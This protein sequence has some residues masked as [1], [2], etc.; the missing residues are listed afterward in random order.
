MP[1]ALLRPWLPLVSDVQT[2]GASSDHSEMTTRAQQRPATPRTI[3]RT[4]E[5]IRLRPRSEANRRRF[6]SWVP[7]L[8]P[9]PADPDA[10]P[11]RGRDP[12]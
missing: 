10:A 1:A 3:I 12:G 5:I 6:E 11:G 9:P 4:V 8:L 2:A 7:R